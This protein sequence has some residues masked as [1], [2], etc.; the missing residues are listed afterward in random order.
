MKEVWKDTICHSKEIWVSNMGNVKDENLKD[1]TQN[2]SFRYDRFSVGRYREM[3]H[4]WVAFL[5]CPNPDGKEIV[6]HIN[7]NRRDNRAC[8]LMWCN[9]EEHTLLHG[10]H[11][12]VMQLSED[13]KVIATFDT[14]RGAARSMGK[15]SHT[16]ISL[17]CAGKRKTAYGYR[18]RWKE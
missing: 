4:I 3:T 11:S 16:A 2:H 6:H 10:G 5:F 14:A 17:C 12:G 8:N 15:N 18:W 9:P 1:K 7:G 13:G